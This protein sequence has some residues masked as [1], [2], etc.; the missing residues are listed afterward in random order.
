MPI[1]K[2]GAKKETGAPILDLPQAKIKVLEAE[3]RTEP[4]EVTRKD[5]ST[6]EMEP[7]LNLKLQI[8]DDLD[9]GDADGTI[10]YDT[11]KLKQDEDGDWIVR[12]G[13][14][15]GALAR[16][17]YGNDFFETDVVFDE[18][19]FEDWVF[20][21]RVEPKIN[22]GTGKVSGSMLT[23]NTIMRLPTPKKKKGKTASSNGRGTAG[24]LVLGTD[25]ENL[26]MDLP[27]EEE[28]A[29]RKALR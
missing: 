1:Q 12:D 6:F 28:E 4:Y 25:A 15:C 24:E 7:N 5:G 17:R 11:A 22:L 27:P 9:E 23:W 8:I 2:K 29:M 13:T 19:D 10:F 14:K 16:A 26:S 21:S 20:M 18:A 3:L